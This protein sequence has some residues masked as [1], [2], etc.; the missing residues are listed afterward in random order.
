M[1]TYAEVLNVLYKASMAWKDPFEPGA[2][3][4]AWRWAFVAYHFSEMLKARQMI[5][6]NFYNA[7]NRD[8][9]DHTGDT[10]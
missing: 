3:I 2:E 6:D 10:P 4:A 1:C 7:K 8:E 5:Q 9:E